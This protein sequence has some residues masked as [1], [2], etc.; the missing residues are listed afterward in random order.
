MLATINWLH[1]YHQYITAIELEAQLEYLKIYFD[2][3][4]D[5]T[6]ADIIQKK[7]RKMPKACKFYF[8]QVTF[9]KL[10][11]NDLHQ[12]YAELETGFKRQSHSKNLT[13]AYFLLFTKK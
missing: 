1:T 4:E 7:K 12:F 10:L 13:A 6:L 3:K 11:V 2:Q 9:L 8:S 5:T